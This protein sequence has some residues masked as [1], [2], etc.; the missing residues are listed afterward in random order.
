MTPEPTELAAAALEDG[1]QL[2]V[3]LGTPADADVVVDL[4]HRAFSARPRI[5]AA[6][7]A[8]RDDRAA[9]AARMA[10]GAA[11]L[12]ELDGDLVG[13]VMAAPHGGGTRLGR[14]CVAPGSRR[15]GLGGFLVGIVLE[16][17]A[18][19][20][21]RDVHL[22]AREEFPQVR[23][24]WERHG[25]ARVGSE[26]DCHI[27][28]RA[29]PI[30]LE[31]PDADAMRAL[32]H[33]LAG[34]LR[35]GDLIIASGDLGAGKT[36]LTQG[37]GAGLG[38]RGPVISPTFVLSRI[39]PSSGDGPALVHVDAYRLGGFAELE[40]ID[41]YASW[42]ESVTLVEW[43]TGVAEPLASD[44]LEIDIRRGLD[45]ED[46]T[47]W[48]FVTPLGPRWDHAALAAALKEEA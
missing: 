45:P 23:A 46:E 47:R 48:V 4:V 3:R 35:A 7:E 24:W 31:V 42:A 13:V 9:V 26:G 29:L 40:D 14:V 5:G 18:V 44:R 22:L 38:V 30:A 2:R 11:Y 20:G 28:A 10:H 39:H 8:L 37:I 36:T 32:G 12:A 21:T 1:R 15:L 34:Q 33:R 16:H 27:M 17:L 19:G 25:F 43:G 41:L 6:P